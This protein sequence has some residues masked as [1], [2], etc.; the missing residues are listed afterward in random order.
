MPFS[1]LTDLALDAPRTAAKFTLQAMR[2][3]LGLA[4]RRQ[5]VDDIEWAWL[6]GGT[7]DG[8]PLVL[9]HGFSG[10]KD[11]WL[12][13]APQFV[14]DYRVICPDL[15][16][17]GGSTRDPD[18]DHGIAPQV[19]RLAAFLD[20]LGI[21]RCHLG[22]N[23]L[24]GF[25]ALAFAL[26]YPDR[27]LSLSLFN[28]AGVNGPEKTALQD[29]MVAGKNPIR[30]ESRRDLDRLLALV[31]HRPPYIPLLVKYLILA[32]HRR[33]GALLDHIF[34]QVI[35]DA[36]ERPLDDRLG[37][38]RVP[39]IIF[40]GEHDRLLHVSA[41]TFQHERIPGSELVVFDDVGHVPMIERPCV[42]AARHRAFLERVGPLPARGG[43]G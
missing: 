37:E 8:E 10:S 33:H 20:M 19:E 5:P 25:V 43:A 4:T 15:P 39:T 3:S 28:N 40:W 7:P 16:G 24:G 17:F 41:A 11:N 18:N 12:F 38:I 23:S 42:T 1:T 9:L 14:G 36:L 26:E 29:A 21:E 13:Y 27:L 6:E 35:S 22:G 2:L 34:G 31:I 32:E 30:L